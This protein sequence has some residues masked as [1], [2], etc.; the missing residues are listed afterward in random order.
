MHRRLLL[1]LLLLLSTLVAAAAQVQTPT[2]KLERELNRIETGIGEHSENDERLVLLRVEIDKLSKSLIDF[3]V[4]FRPELT[5]INAR[6]EE[7]GPAPKEGDPAEPEIVAKERKELLARKV[8]INAQL[9]AAERLSIRASDASAQI[10]DLRRELFANTLFRRT[11]SNGIFNAENWN[12]FKQ[13]TWKAWRTIASRL[14]F[15]GTFRLSSLLTAS[16]LSIVLVV[17]VWWLFDRTLG[18]LLHTRRR[19]G[20]L[21]YF[22]RLS[23]AFWS[24]VVP[25]LAFCAGLGI[26]YWLFFSFSIFSGQSLDLFRAFLV[27]LAAFFF[28]QQLVRSIF[29]PRH[30]ER[31][32]T[33]FTNGGAR[34]MSILIM[35]MA[36]VHIVDFFLGWVS[37]IYSSSLAVTVGQSMVAA[38]TIGFLLILTALVKPYRNE[39]TGAAMPLPGVIR[40]PMILIA[41][42]VIAAAVSGYVGLAK[43]AA[44]QIV[45][46]GAIIATMLIGFQTGRALGTDGALAQ[47][48]LGRRVRARFDLTD[49]ALDQFGLLLSLGVYLLVGLV[50]LPL[51]ALQWGFNRV[52]VST[53][54]YQLMTNITIGSMSISLFAILFGIILFVAGYLLTRQFQNWLD[55]SVMARSRID[56]GVRNSIR[57][58]TGYLGIGLAALIGISAAGFDLSNLA[59]VAGALSLGIGFGLQNIV[60]NFV[61]GLILLAERPFKVGDWIVAGQ[62]AGTVKR[63]SVRATEIET[64]QKQ[65]V[66]LPNSELINQP[67]GNWTHRNH[68]GRVDIAAS[69]AYGT[70]PRMIHDLLLEIA[71]NDPSVLKVPPPFVV[72]LGFGESALNFELRFHVKDVLEGS[73]IATRIR[74]AIVDAFEAKNIQIPFPQRDLNIK[75]EDLQNLLSSVAKPAKRKPATPKSDARKAIKKSSPRNGAPQ[76]TAALPAAKPAKA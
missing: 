46:T 6:L 26:V 72:F 58:I 1:A 14:Q 50:G 61:S 74:F 16:G 45:I 57:T 42:F 12:A 20:E 69:V 64:F 25:S 67:V 51:I 56:T 71:A 32:L 36:G 5:R 48:A 29:A 24:T 33:A 35:A 15:V 59:I 53:F 39:Q 60:N 31:R 37:D 28:I 66:I 52:D 18:R 4:S 7:L 49:T 47:S 27:S 41:G 75:T 21:S 2:E 70:N 62:T 23:L 63:I 73:V 38:L 30:P 76:E 11:T 19:D 10:S 55:R 40:L 43:F 3:G 34:A 8:E 9:A 54:L 13:D 65:T 22:S 17:A 68:L 44:G